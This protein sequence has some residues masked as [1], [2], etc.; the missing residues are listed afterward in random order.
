MASDTRKA[1]VERVEEC[2]LKYDSTRFWS[3]L[4]NLSGKKASHSPNQYITFGNKTLT[5]KPVIATHFCKQ[6]TGASP[7][8]N[9]AFR[10]IRR[11]IRTD[12]PLDPHFSPFSTQ[13]VSEALTAAGTS[14]APGPDGLTIL[15]LRNL[16]PAGIDYLTS[17]FNHSIASANI[18]AIWKSA[19]I[20]T[21]PKPGKPPSSSTS[22]RPISLLCPAAK[23]LERLILPY[24]NDHLNLSSTQHGFRSSRSTTSALLP[25]VNSITSNINQPRP[26]PRT[27]ALAVD[28][29]K[30]F[31]TVPHD[32]L[33]V[34]LSQSSLPPNIV[35]WLSC[36]LRGRL[37][38]CS[39]EGIVSP[40]R[41]VG[42]GVPQGSVIS[43]VLFNFFV[44]DYPNTAPIISSYADD[45]TA[46]A[47]AV[48]PYAAANQLSNHAADVSYWADRKG[49][50]ISVPKSHCILFTLDT[51]QS[52]LNPEV[53]WGEELL[54]VVRR[55]KI[56]GVT[57]DTHHSF[58]PHI[59]EVAE[60]ARS[61]LNILRALAGT[62]W[63]QD[64]ETLLTTFKSL[65]SS[66]LHYASPIWFP[67][68]SNTALGKLQ[69]IQNAALRIATGG[70]R[71]TSIDHLHTESSVL[72]LR[73]SLSLRCQQYLLGALRPDHPAHPIVTTPPGP[74][75][76]R[77][78]LQSAFLPDVEHFLVDGALP[79]D[80]YREALR[81]VHTG[82]VRLAMDETAPN[83]VLGTHPPPIDPSERGLNRAQRTALSQL[84]RDT[85]P[86]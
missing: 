15:H 8:R 5:S 43:P 57:L 64:K 38:R 63:G 41:P 55:C 66:V 86:T 52:H 75:N 37:A 65:I 72:P 68:T 82:M 3:L 18:P 69:V 48:N 19:T 9:R 46:L 39:Y 17:I 83:R 32:R 26:P 58:T 45:F 60:R 1:W 62:G 85:P 24:L 47:S 6:F 76:L 33:I 11:R 80:T 61:R 10:S 16:G 36:Y 59:D 34:Q 44:S 30:A 74:R 56:L 78:T 13:S 23:V 71:M 54:P 25:I 7:P 42:A 40:F 35:R 2:S 21:I 53:R 12:H 29:S 77:R 84:A 22:Y 49:L 51:H 27:V 31:D 50:K 73:N 70:L 28:F 81:E 14:T 20:T 79:P 67:N 4:R